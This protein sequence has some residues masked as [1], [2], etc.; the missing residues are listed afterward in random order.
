ML[1]T[2]INKSSLEN[3]LVGES[4]SSTRNNPIL[5]VPLFTSKPCQR[6]VDWKSSK[7]VDQTMKLTIV[8]TAFKIG[9]R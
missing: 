9:Q 7:N 6:H 5:M 1:K 2:K 3:A 8:P 4:E